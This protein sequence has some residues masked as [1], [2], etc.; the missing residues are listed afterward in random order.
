[1]HRLPATIGTRRSQC[2]IEAQQQFRMGTT[3]QCKAGTQG[4]I[5]QLWQAELPR[6]QTLRNGTTG[7]HVERCQIGLA[8]QHHFERLL[9]MLG[10]Q[11]LQRRV[12]R[13]QMSP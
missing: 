2:G 8:A 1:M 13:L 12:F 5:G 7:M 10:R 9:V 3:A 4:H 6:K 11:Q